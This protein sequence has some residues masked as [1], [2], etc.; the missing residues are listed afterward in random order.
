MGGKKRE[1]GKRGTSKLLFLLGE[2]KRGGEPASGFGGASPNFT[3]KEMEKKKVQYY[4][5]LPGGK[6]GERARPWVDLAPM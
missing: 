5:N 1:G 4:L 3:R 2:K 6:K